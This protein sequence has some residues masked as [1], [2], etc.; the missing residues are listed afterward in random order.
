MRKAYLSVMVV[1]C[2][3]SVVLGPAVPDSPII[4]VLSHGMEH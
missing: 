4:S 1:F 3:L 2:L